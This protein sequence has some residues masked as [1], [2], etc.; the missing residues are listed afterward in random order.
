[1]LLEETELMVA[2]SALDP[3]KFWPRFAHYS[4]FPNKEDGGKHPLVYRL[5]SCSPYVV[6]L[7]FKKVGGHRP[8]ADVGSTLKEKSDIE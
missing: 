8:G 1:M 3:A 5:R 7:G 2:V 4:H 6:S